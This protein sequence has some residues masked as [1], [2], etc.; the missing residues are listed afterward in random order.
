[1]RIAIFTDEFLPQFNGVVSYVLDTCEELVRLGHEV[2][3]FAPR[4]KRGVKLDTKKF[5]FQLVLLPSLPA[6]LYPDFRLTIPALPRVLLNLRRFKPDVVHV[7]DPLTIGTDGIMAAKVRK[8]PIVITFHTFFMD[9]DILSYFKLKKRAK[10]IQKRLWRLTAFYHNLASAVICPSLVSETELEKH[11]LKKPAVVVHNGIDLSKIKKISASEKVEIRLSYG[12]K[13][14]EATAIFIGRLAQDKSINIVVEAWQRV[15]KKLP[16][17]K[18]ILVGFGPEQEKLKIQTRELNISPNVVFLGAAK[19]NQIFTRGIYYLGD[20]FVTA[21]KIENQ[22]L[23]MLEAMAH[24]LPLVGVKARGTPELISGNGLMVEPDNA[25]LLASAIIKILR[26]PKLREK[27]GQSSQEKAK[28]FDL[29]NSVKKLEAVYRVLTH[30]K[31][32]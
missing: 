2:L 8:I 32:L 11:G 9:E 28:E 24:G 18:L 12:I 7:M 15:V 10:F 29:K 21:S 23:S 27:M 20:V 25:E 3:V 16:K 19:R 4:P 31:T 13:K 6:F 17:A 30:F 14:D 5:S 26:D 1:M 22:S